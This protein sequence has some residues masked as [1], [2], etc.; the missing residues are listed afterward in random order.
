MAAG[1]RARTAPLYERLVA[2]RA[3]GLTSFHVPGHKSGRGL[4]PLAKGDLEQVMAIDYTEITGLDDLHDPEGVIREAQELAADCFGADET[5]FLVGGSTVGNLAMI[6]A[7]CGRGELMLV[8]RNVHKS[9]IHGLMLAGARAVFLPP[10]RDEASGLAFAPDIAVVREA[11][12]RYPEAKALFLSNPDYYGTG[13]DLR[14]YA[15]LA[16]VCGK[17]LLVDEAHGAHYGFHPDLPPSALSCGADA[18]VQ[19][20]HKMLTAMTMG[21]MLHVRGERINRDLL[22]FR[23]GMLQSSSPSYPIMASLDLCRRS[24][25]VR[26]AELFERGLAAVRS[27]AAGLARLESFAAARPAAVASAGV[28]KTQDPFKVA[29]RDQTGTL[30][31]YELKSE[32]ERRG[33]MVEMADPD[34]VLL[35]FSLA[36]SL[37]DSERL[38]S[39]LRDIGEE[40]RLGGREPRPGAWQSA[41]AAPFRRISAP[42][43]MDMRVPGLSAGGEG[44]PPTRLVPIRE[45]AGEICAEMVIPYPP[46]VPVL[47]PGE[48][49]EREM[50][51]YIAELAASG[52]RFHGWRGAADG[53]LRI[54]NNG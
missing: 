27:F 37:Q 22:K 17:P 42:V 38:L 3:A 30:T 9:V 46:G 21:A 5:H 4:D 54:M 36:S 16:H 12:A 53:M 6:T 15:E 47:F 44:S 23:L 18:V 31:G 20:T 41:A 43:P 34:Y 32:L 45:A 39:A 29:V 40:R 13:V 1:H 10:Q 33:C 51:E 7:V 50:A 35:V 28:L 24:L 26:G 19:S 14:P 11:F 25:H 8:Q 52:A 49:I 2:C 48:P